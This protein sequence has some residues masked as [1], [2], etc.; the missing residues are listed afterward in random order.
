MIWQCELLFMPASIWSV[1]LVLHVSQ[2]Q[3]HT[4]DLEM[5]VWRKWRPWETLIKYIVETVELMACE[6]SGSY[7]I[8]CPVSIKWLQ[9]L[10]G[11]VKALWIFPFFC[12]ISCWENM[13]ALC[14][15]LEGFLH[16]LVITFDLIFNRVNMQQTECTHKWYSM[17]IYNT[18]SCLYWTYHVSIYSAGWK[19]YVNP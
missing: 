8:K 2:M 5:D 15:Y 14:I 19:K 6:S 17:L 12:I 10:Y 7:Q 13:W 11:N 9:F 18:F 16:N 3:V 4:I 1:H